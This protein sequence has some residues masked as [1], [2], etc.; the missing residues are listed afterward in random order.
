[1]PKMN[2]RLLLS[3]IAGTIALPG[4]ARAVPAPPP[5]PWRLKLSN[6]HTHETFNGPYRDDNGP[7]PSAM[8]ELAVFLRDF[9]SGEIIAMD[10]AALDFLYAVMAATGQD[11]AQILSA[12]RTRATNEMLARTT[13][14]VAENSQHIFGR[15]LDVHFGAKLPEAMQTARAM[16]RGGVGWYPNSGFI[17]I[18][19]GPVRNWDLYDS[20][21]GNLLFNGGNVHFNDKGELV[22][23]A[24]HGHGMPLMM[25]GGRPPSVRQRMAR[26]H[27][28]ARAEFLARH[29]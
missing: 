16:Q 10:V 11:E 18:D 3:I 15:A 26:L 5:G 1:M 23:S 29:R 9:H 7:I 24:G 21:L 8:A 20:G 17:H 28:L 2:R 22:A 12:Y 14:G 19:S 6:Q 13:F 25:G 4:M 27:Q